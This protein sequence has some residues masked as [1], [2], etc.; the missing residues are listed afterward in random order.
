MNDIYDERDAIVEHWI[1][2]RHD[3]PVGPMLRL[4]EILNHVIEG[5]ALPRDTSGLM[6]RHTLATAACP[7]LLRATPDQW[8]AEQ[9]GL[10]VCNIALAEASM[11][12]AVEDRVL[13]VELR[14]WHRD[15]IDRR[16]WTVLAELLEMDADGGLMRHGRERREMRERRERS[17]HPSSRM[18]SG[19]GRRGRGTCAGGVRSTQR[20]T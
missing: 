8:T 9:V 19:T 11:A 14:Q 5:D 18:E 7:G 2:G 17:A 20:E 13:D 16:Q 3:C 12:R 15:L 10:Q 1:E 6:R 4:D